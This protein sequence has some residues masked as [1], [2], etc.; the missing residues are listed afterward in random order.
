MLA[1]R[2]LA[3]YVA[4]ARDEPLSAE[5]R[6]AALR[7]ILDLLAATAVGVGVPGV[8]AVRQVARASYGAG[9]FPLWFTGESGSLIGS[10]WAN[11]AAAAA[12]D[13]DDG[14]RLARGHPGAAIIPAAFAVAQE[15]GASLDQLLSAI[16]IGYE[17]GIAVGAARRFYANSGMWTCYGVVAA[18]GALRRLPPAQLAHAFAIAGMSAPNQLHVGGGPA[19][20]FPIGSDVKEGIPWSTVTALQAVSLAEAGHTGPENLLDSEAHFAVADMLAGLGQRLHIGRSYF[21]FYSCCRH[22]HPPV[23]ALRGL[24][25]RHE[26]EP[27]RIEAI[28]VH[29]YSGALRLANPPEPANFVDVQFSIPYCLGL[30]AL[31]GPETLLP[32]T[33][34]AFGRADAVAFA[35][36]VSL[37]LDAA[38]DG[39]FPAET[40]AR[41]VVTHGGERHESP[42]TAPHGEASAPASWQE[43]EEKLL[44]ASRLIATPDQQQHIL[45]AVA[46]LRAGDIVSLKHV[47][48]TLVLGQHA[49][50][51]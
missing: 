42:A 3:D 9:E 47:L 15:R 36:K 41:L 14:N 50:A 46:R 39:R 30:V 13:L 4:S 19:Q 48:A 35:R 2:H 21:K 31:H 38:L 18:A 33:P 34:D 12:L 29:T 22:I 27:A 23:D 20:P 1:V 44:V 5:A 10:V 7:C 26:L 11:C 28:E 43:L 24:I 49:Q 25:A 32:L 37:H 16:T 40:L 8:A 51:A 6:E 45:A 17:V